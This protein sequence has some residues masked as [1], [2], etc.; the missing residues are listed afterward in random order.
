MPRRSPC[1]R[2]YT[3]AKAT[4]EPLRNDEQRALVNQRRAPY[5]LDAWDGYPA[6]RE[7]VLAV[8][9]NLDKNLISLAGDTHNAWASD[10]TDA[11][12][13]HVAWS[14]PLHRS[15][16]PASNARCR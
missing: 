8:A 3:L 12:G 5:N 7:S 4:P 2:E 9:R 15:V 1:R 10:L 14:S 6:A 13:Q 11:A 16:R